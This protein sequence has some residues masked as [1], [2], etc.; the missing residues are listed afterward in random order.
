VHADAVAEG[1]MADR[2]RVGSLVVSSKSC[3]R[4]KWSREHDMHR[5][6]VRSVRS[7]TDLSKPVT[8]EMDHCHNNLKKERLLEDRYIEIDREN[9]NLLRKMSQIVKKPNSYAPETNP[10]NP[11]SLNKTGRKQE[12]LH[13]TKENQRMLKA[14]QEVQP[15]YNAAR[16]DEDDRRR[17]ALLRN[18]CTYPVC[19]RMERK[20]SAPSVLIPL[21]TEAGSS[22][23]DE[24]KSG[25]KDQDDR[26]TLLTEGKRIGNAYFL[27]EMSTD[28]KTLSVSAYEGESKTSLELVV[29]EKRHREL[30]R[31]FNGD[32]SAIASRLRL[33]KDRLIIDTGGSDGRQEPS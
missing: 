6:R 3:A 10:N 18:C 14:L 31:E 32:Y 19:I 27:I 7:A 8:M 20:R 29:N 11:V 12:L 30:Y 2:G 26:K 15:V 33:D 5:A 25:S 13:I 28:G 9:Q 24:T 21:G 23:Q 1:A 17:E 22:R 4:R 16:W